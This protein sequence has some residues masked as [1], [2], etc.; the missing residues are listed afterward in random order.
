MVDYV[1]LVQD[2]FD[3]V[4]QYLEEGEDRWTYVT[5]I[6][7]CS[8]HKRIS[9][10]DNPIHCV[11]TQAT[12]PHTAA[13]IFSFIWSLDNRRLWDEYIKE[14]K[15]IEDIQGCPAPIKEASVVYMS[16][17]APFPISHRD[18]CNLRAYK[19][20]DDGTYVT[21]ATSTTHPDV[22]SEVRGHVRGQLII[23]GFW[24][25]PNKENPNHTDLK[26]IA[27]LDPKGSIPFWAINLANR[28]V[29]MTMAALKN[30]MAKQLNV[31]Q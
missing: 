8:M 24:M 25:T 20:E 27:H 9:G 1:A 11:R 28:K 3:R 2:S 7:G 30:V 26:Y 22:P 4:Q 31:Q 29:P 15:V 21:T 16:F 10:D 18:F 12:F 14:V 5:E 13:E 6:E 19:I 17:S 23:D